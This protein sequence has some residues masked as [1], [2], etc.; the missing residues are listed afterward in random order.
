MREATAHFVQVRRERPGD[1]AAIAQV[2]DAAFGQPDESRIVDAVRRAGHP[3]ISLVAVDGAKIVGHI[4]F[5]PVAFE[6]PGAVLRMMA[7]GPMAALPEIQRQG[8][9]SKLVET[10]LRECERVG[11]QA[12]VVIGHPEYYPRFGFRP[13]REHGLRSEYA[14]PDEAF[15]VVEL[16]AGALLGR[17][18]LVRYVPEFG[19]AGR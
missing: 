14:V 10:G 2:N 5:T 3:A 18:G 9:G 8:I 12:V 7:L 4:L 15:M 17:S 1:E 19:S 13:A 11:C 16:A 6:S